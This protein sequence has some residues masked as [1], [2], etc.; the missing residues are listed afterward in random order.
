V[1]RQC[2]AAIPKR[3]AMPGSFIEI[4]GRAEGGQLRQQEVLLLS[5]F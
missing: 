1:G 4:K 2:F 5:M 3:N